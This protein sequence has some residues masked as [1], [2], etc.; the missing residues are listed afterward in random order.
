MLTKSVPNFGMVTVCRI[1]KRVFLSDTP[2]MCR[3]GSSVGIA[4]DY[5]L[6]GPGIES[7]L[8]ARFS[9]PFQTGPG[10]HTA[11]C[12]MGTGSFPEVK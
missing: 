4:T 7:R 8:E 10:A 12:K 9:A 11:S 3:P 6:E 2:T 1:S 5:G